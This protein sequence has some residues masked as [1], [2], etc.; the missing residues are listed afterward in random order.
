M[1]S[2]ISKVALALVAACNA[3]QIFSLESL[4]VKL[5]FTIHLY[6]YIFSLKSKL[7]LL[8]FYENNHR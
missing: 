1:Y 5:F 7:Y 6:F 3:P 2:K 4:G 8:Y